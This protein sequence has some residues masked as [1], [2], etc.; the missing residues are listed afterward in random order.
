[1]LPTAHERLY[2]AAIQFSKEELAD[3]VAN[4]MIHRYTDD[5]IIIM[6]VLLACHECNDALG[7][8]A[9][10]VTAMYPGITTQEQAIL[11]QAV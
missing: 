5:N 6:R 10:I 8:F 7:N 2:K 9:D 11:F 4:M 1:M 3:C